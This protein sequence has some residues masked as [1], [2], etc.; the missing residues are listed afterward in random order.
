MNRLKQYLKIAGWL[1][2][3][4]KTPPPHIIKQKTILDYARRYH[5]P[6]MVE[7]GTLFGDM[8]EAMKDHFEELISIEISP[9]LA[10]KAQQRFAGSG[11]IKVIENDSAVALKSIVPELE[12]PALFWLDGHYSGGN[13]GKGEKD[14]PIMDELESIYQSALDHVVLIDDARLFGIDKDYPSMEQLEEFIR[15]RRPNAIITM[16]ND[17]IRIAPGHR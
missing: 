11:K 8:I 1:A 3:G 7:T 5:T 13:T 16:K 17:C 12:Q 9:E 14:T 6:V 15:K 10:K 2:G 4:R